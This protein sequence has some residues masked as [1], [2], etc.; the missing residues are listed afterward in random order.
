[1]SKQTSVDSGSIEEDALERA[2]TRIY[3]GDNDDDFMISSMSP[4]IDKQ[5]SFDNP[6]PLSLQNGRLSKADDIGKEPE[7]VTELSD[8]VTYMRA[9]GKFTSF[10]DCDGISFIFIFSLKFY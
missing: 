8:L 5:M 10:V 6:T 7:L 1:M 9:M 2:V 4:K 3:I